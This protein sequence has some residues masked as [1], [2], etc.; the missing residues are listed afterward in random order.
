MSFAAAHV[1]AVTQAS[2][3]RWGSIVYPRL[4]VL[5][6]GW[7]GV[8]VWGGVGGQTAIGRNAHSPP[9]SSPP[10]PNPPEAGAKKIGTREV[11]LLSGMLKSFTA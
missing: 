6:V 5:G 1:G 9:L 8:G 10:P 2:P 7:G 3:A 11:T 4:S